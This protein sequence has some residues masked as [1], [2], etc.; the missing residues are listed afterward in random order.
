MLFHSMRINSRYVYHI[1][2]NHIEKISENYNTC[3]ISYFS[4]LLNTT[5]T[6]QKIMFLA[7]FLNN[8]AG[9]AALYSCKSHNKKS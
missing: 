8:K 9:M 3:I 4:D 7:I 2:A 5:R 1:T 6:G